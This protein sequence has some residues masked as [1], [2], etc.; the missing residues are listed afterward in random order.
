[1][2]LK[3]DSKDINKSD[4]PVL[5]NV[6]NIYD[7]KELSETEQQI[8]NLKLKQIRQ[9]RLFTDVLTSKETLLNLH[10]F[11]FGDIYEWAG[12]IREID[13]VKYGFKFSNYKCIEQNLDKFF[14]DLKKDN[15]LYGFTK[16]EFAEIFTE[17]SIDLDMI[18]PFRE[19]NSR[20]RRCFMSSIA[21]KAGW[22]I[23]FLNVDYDE[24]INAE[25]YSLMGINGHTDS[26]YMKKLVYDN[27]QPVDND[28][29]TQQQIEC[30]PLADRLTRFCWCYDRIG[31]KQ[32]K[33]K[34]KSVNEAKKAV[35]AMLSVDFGK[36]EICKVLNRIIDYENILQNNRTENLYNFRQTTINKAAALKS[37][38]LY[39]VKDKT[40]IQ[41]LFSASDC[42]N[43][44]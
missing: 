40:G 8:V 27:L 16:E 39:A 13:L 43:T 14:D 10:R 41:N 26:A 17:Q 15:Y 3:Y 25:V 44:I 29:I 31:P 23:D 37:E 30:L 42:I 32:F 11:L 22:Q 7:K 35:D 36:M 38:V 5:D 2:H 34:F 33:N 21:E 20:S 1:M 12:T 28:Y 6:L 9:N 24:L 19:G 4:L 18:H